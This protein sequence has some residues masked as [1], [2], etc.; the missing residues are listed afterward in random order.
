MKK[1]TLSLILIAVMIL[2]LLSACAGNSDKQTN[3]DTSPATDDK[4]PTTNEESPA[5]S[6]SEPTELAT[7]LE[8]Y[9]FTIYYNYDWWTIKPWGEDS[10]S[11]YWKEK[12]NLTI[13]HTKPD[14]D[15]A[16]KL[17]LMISGGDLPDVIEMDRTADWRR[18]AKM[19]LF[20]DLAPLQAANPTLDENVAQSTQELLKIDGKL[21]SVPHWVRKGPTGGNDVW[22]YDKRLY[23]Q[24]GSPPLK[25][26]EDLYAYAKNVKDNIAT[27]KEGLPVI[28]FSTENNANAF[29]KITGAFYRSMGG[30]NKTTTYTARI[31][32]KI[33]S[34]LRD[35]VF[36]A[37]TMEANKW[38]REGLI[39]ETQFSNDQIIE[40]FTSGRTAL[41]Y[42]DHSQDSVNRFRQILMNTYPDDTY[43]IVVDPVYPP[44]QGVDHVFA[45][46]KETIGWNVLN[47]TTKTEKPQRIFD[48]LT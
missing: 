22:M 21:Y 28:P 45:D 43:E 30:A 25:T 48:F 36:R 31:D 14:A 35:P 32:G 27:T 10:T 33:Q 47:I 40:K 13:E 38:Y 20:V 6:E 37:A 7:D 15:A 44:A 8:P 1:K 5:P 18:M 16:A 3:D 29:D 46:H 19:D 11:K 12:F 42:Y 23:E 4:S 9:T 26:F 39:A 41:L 24:A 34:V 2:S 17:N